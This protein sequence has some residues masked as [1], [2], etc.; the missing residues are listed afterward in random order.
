MSAPEAAESIRAI[1][2]AMGHILRT[3]FKTGEHPR[4]CGFLNF[5]FISGGY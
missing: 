5:T 3:V 1:V 4:G 2:K